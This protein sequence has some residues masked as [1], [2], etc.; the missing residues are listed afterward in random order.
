MS[1]SDNIKRS[2]FW[3]L[4]LLWESPSGNGCV[5][6]I[7]DCGAVGCGL[8][9]DD[10]GGAFGYRDRYGD[11]VLLFLRTSGC[12]GGIGKNGIVDEGEKR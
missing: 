10:S 4:V 9:K 3:G 6:G 1:K 12:A 2:E 5:D 8:K 11:Y 7:S